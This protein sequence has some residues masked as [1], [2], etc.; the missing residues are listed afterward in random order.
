MKHLHEFFLKNFG[1]EV[2]F[3]NAEE[4]LTKL[5]EH[6]KT[7]FPQQSTKSKITRYT[8]DGKPVYNDL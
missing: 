1:I 6:F 4:F 2:Y 3:G 8:S 7:R 5:Q